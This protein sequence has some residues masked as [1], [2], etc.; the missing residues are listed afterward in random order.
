MLRK[1]GSETIRY[2]GKKKPTINPSPAIELIK[3]HNELNTIKSHDRIV[4]CDGGHPRLGHPRVYLNLDEGQN[5]CNYC[6]QKFIHDKSHG[7][8]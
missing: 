8:H 2:V 1:V 7:H 3:K 5:E 4:S 6:G